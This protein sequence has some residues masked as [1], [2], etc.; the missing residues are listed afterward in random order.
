[1]PY[2]SYL[3]TVGIHQLCRVINKQVTLLAR[4]PRVQQVS[5]VSSIAR[6]IFS[7]VYWNSK[8]LLPSSQ[9]YSKISVKETPRFVAASRQF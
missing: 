2:I 4:H 7:G 3:A 6:V 5:A 8:L 1:V 9:D